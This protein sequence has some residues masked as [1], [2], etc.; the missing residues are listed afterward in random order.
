MFP[1]LFDLITFDMRNQNLKKESNYDA[2][3][4]CSC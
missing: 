3:I 2:K 1:K 4:K